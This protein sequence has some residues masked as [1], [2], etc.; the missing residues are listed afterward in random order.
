MS[1]AFGETA[2]QSSRG[3]GS[4]G[5][6][7]VL[8]CRPP[9]PGSWLRASSILV[10]RSDRGQGRSERA[11]ETKVARIPQRRL[12]AVEAACGS[13]RVC[14]WFTAP[15]EAAIVAANEAAHGAGAATRLCRAVGG[16]FASLTYITRE[17]RE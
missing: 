9:G 16:M 1:P 17:V 5:G 4:C 10:I 15:N 6:V 13:C 8:V 3:P 14:S 11:L 7:V 2:R 12:T